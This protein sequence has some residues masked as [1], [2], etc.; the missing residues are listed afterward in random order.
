[1]KH[2]RVALF[3]ALLFV[4]SQAY[5]LKTIVIFNNNSN[6]ENIGPM[7]LVSV[8]PYDRQT[9]DVA[10]KEIV[11]TFSQPLKP[12]KSSIKVYDGVGGQIETG[13]LEADG[14]TMSVTLPELS[15]G[16]YSI[17]W[18]ARCL[19]DSDTQLSNTSRFTVR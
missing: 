15:Y 16:K 18:R 7:R 19:C 2:S 6:Q 3:L 4:C 1:M 13:P 12:D 10:P 14:H 9:L 8:K 11:F 17:K 5:A